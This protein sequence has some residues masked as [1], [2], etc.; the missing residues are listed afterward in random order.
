[1][2]IAVDRIDHLVLTVFDIDRTLEFYKRVLGMEPITFAGE[3][4]PLMTR[5]SAKIAPA[6]RASAILIRASGRTR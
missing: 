4:M 2:A 3:A 6:T 1:M 5:P